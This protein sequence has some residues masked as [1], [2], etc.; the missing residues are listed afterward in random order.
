M[1]HSLTT[2]MAAMALTF[3]FSTG[4]VEASP[5][6]ADNHITSE[7]FANPLFRNGADPW[8]AYHN[9]NYYLTTTDRKS[10]V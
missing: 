9:G 7:T 3:G 10:V 6:P 8:L 1:T 5:V 2:L 4:V